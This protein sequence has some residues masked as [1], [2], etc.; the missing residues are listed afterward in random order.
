M[1][2]IRRSQNTLA[3]K[4]PLRDTVIGEQEP[5]LPNERSHIEIVIHDHEH[6]H[7]VGFMFAGDKRAKHDKPRQMTTFNRDLVDA[8]EAASDQFAAIRTRSKAADSFSK[9]GLVNAD[10]QIAGLVEFR[11]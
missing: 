5:G 1:A 6:V 9:R 8:F 3:P 2:A 11:Q 4:C 10:R 7:I